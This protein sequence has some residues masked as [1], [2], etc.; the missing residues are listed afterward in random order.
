M[1]R[2]NI[3][4]T[5]H[6]GRRDTLLGR[7][8]RLAPFRPAGY[9]NVLIAQVED[10]ADFLERL[11]AVLAED[12]VL[13]EALARIVPVEVTLRFDPTAA[14]DSL[15]AAAEPLIPRLAGGS[16]FVRVER[17][18]FKGRLHTPTLERE[19]G[20]RVWRALEARG[21]HPRVAFRDP[22]AILVVETLGERAGLGIV[23]RALRGTYPFVNLR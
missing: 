22:D 12:R 14:A 9:R 15:A 3:L 11:R 17:R 10:Q 2:W 6:E 20:D 19:L 4:A 5:A 7:L 23:P 13:A 18:G 16:F 21:E 1:E 8:R